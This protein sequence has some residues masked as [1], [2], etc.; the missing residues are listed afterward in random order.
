MKNRMSLAAL[1]VLSFTVVVMAQQPQ[2]DITR[3][4]P[5][6]WITKWDDLVDKQIVVEGLAWGHDSKGIG[7]WIVLGNG[8]RLY[9]R[10]IDYGREDLNGRVIQFTGTLRKRH[11]SPAPYGAQ[12]YSTHFDYYE[13]E[14][15][16]SRKIVRTDRPWPRLERDDV[17]IEDQKRPPTTFRKATVPK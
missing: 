13:L 11:M 3:R 1:A 4:D 10:G 2:A 5:A 12:G 14:A 17:K 7:P 16:S 6:G 8:D 9:V 15:R